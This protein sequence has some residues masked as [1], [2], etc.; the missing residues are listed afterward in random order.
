MP[1]PIPSK[2]A[3]AATLASDNTH[4]RKQPNGHQSRLGELISAYTAKN[5]PQPMVFD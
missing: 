5:A 4:Y 1:S 2:T 3:G